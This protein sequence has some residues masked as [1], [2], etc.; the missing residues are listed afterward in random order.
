MQRFIANAQQIIQKTL[1]DVDRKEAS[2]LQKD[3]IAELNKE[4]KQIF[5]SVQRKY[6]HDLPMFK[7]LVKGEGIL[8]RNSE[9]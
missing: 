4:A 7:A 9:H 3:A 2:Q 1:L 5:K 8:F 6:Q